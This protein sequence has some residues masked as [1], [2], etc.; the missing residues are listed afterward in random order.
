MYYT[1]DKCKKSFTRSYN[2]TRH[3]K[4]SCVARV[5]YVDKAKKQRL[6]GATSSVMLTCDVCKILVP[7]NHMLAH[8]RTLEHRNK[9]CVSIARGVQRIESAF[10]SRIVSYRLNTDFDHVNYTIFF[11]DITPKVIGVLQ[12]ILHKYKSAK[13]N[14]ITVARYF[15]A[16]NDTF[17]EKS[18]NTPNQIV[19]I[20]SDLNEIFEIFIECMKTQA[21][22][23]QEKDSGMLK[24][25]R[26][27][28]F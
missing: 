28:I 11:K 13:V 22:E 10:R 24:I 14:M 2:L 9:S 17:S 1:C 21:A 5:D 6:D 3:K 26:Y 12:E 23:F 16:A 4:E 15:L 20:G 8:E 19:T 7:R 18:F 27:F 25:N